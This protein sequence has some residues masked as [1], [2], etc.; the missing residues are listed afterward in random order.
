MTT[1]ISYKCFICNDVI[2]KQ[3]QCPRNNKISLC[4]SKCLE[5]FNKEL[6]DEKEIEKAK[7]FYEVNEVREEFVNQEVP[8]N[9]QPAVK[10]HI[11]VRHPGTKTV[12]N[13]SITKN[14]FNI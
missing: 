4:S 11:L 13:K 5:V 12:K 10:K 9:S 7:E 14:I 2:F 8:E 6:V 1:P 3:T